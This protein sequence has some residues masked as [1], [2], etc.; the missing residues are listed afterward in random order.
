[1][2]EYRVMYQPLL[3]NGES[4]ALAPFSYYD[5]PVSLDS[6]EWATKRMNESSNYLA[7]IERR[8]LGDWERFDA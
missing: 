6:A 4:S 8:P 5:N 1:M 3:E 7:W 2:Y